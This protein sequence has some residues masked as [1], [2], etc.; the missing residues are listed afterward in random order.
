MFLI[1][2]P[3]LLIPFAVY[4]MVEFLT[5]GATAGA[6]W[7]HQL[8]SVQMLSGAVWTLTVGELLLALSLLILFI[9]LVK[10]T[11]ISARSFIDHLLSTLLFIG[12]LVE[13]LLVRQAATATFFLLLV[14]SFVDAIGG[15]TITMRA[16]QRNITVDEVETIRRT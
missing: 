9:E 7:T 10:A 12:M 5:P 4:N 6:F 13:F 1:G 15:Y 14:I 8:I 11:R 16:A 3:L 2:V